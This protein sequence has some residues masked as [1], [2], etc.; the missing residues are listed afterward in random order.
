MKLTFRGEPDIRETERSTVHT[1]KEMAKQGNAPILR[2]IL[3]NTPS[4]TS[5]TVPMIA[6]T[7]EAQRHSQI[8]L[9]EGVRLQPQHSLSNYDQTEIR[10]ESSVALAS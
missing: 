6:L 1:D 8:T 2:F 4:G 3:T 9:I 7:Y 5:L 10:N